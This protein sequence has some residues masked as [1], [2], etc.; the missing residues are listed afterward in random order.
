MEQWLE[1]EIEQGIFPS[2][3][4]VHFIDHKGDLVTVQTNV[5]YLRIDVLPREGEMGKGWLLVSLI[6][7]F[8]SETRVKLP[9]DLLTDK[10]T[11]SCLVRRE[12]L[13]DSPTE[14]VNENP[15]VPSQECP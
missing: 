4:A 1:V 13:H 11:R 3:Y 12:A 8:A 15:G 2:L 14:L 9:Y 5:P 7:E 6:G 10:T